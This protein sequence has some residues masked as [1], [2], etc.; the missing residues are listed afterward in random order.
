MYLQNIGS[1]DC[2]YTCALVHMTVITRVHWFI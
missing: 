2:N 1:Y